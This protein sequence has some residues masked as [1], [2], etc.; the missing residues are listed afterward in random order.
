MP[1][2]KKPRVLH[3]ANDV[4]ALLIGCELAFSRIVGE[5]SMRD[6]LDQDLISRLG[7]PY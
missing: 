5:S 6:F 4:L 7:P 2:G 3:V 1:D